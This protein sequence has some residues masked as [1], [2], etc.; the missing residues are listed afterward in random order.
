MKKFIVFIFIFILAWCTSDDEKSQTQS[1]TWENSWLIQ[2]GSQLPKEPQKEMIWEK[3][4]IDVE[5][6]KWK[7][8]F[9]V[10]DA[11]VYLNDQNITW[12]D[13]KTFEVL[14][15]DEA[16]NDCYSKDASKVFLSEGWITRE[17]VWALSGSFEKFKKSF[18]YT[19]DKSNIYF[20]G[21][22]IPVD[23]KSFEV[24]SQFVAKDKNTV[25]V[26]WV[27]MKEFDAQTFRQ[28]EDDIFQDKNFTY[29]ISQWNIQIINE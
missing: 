24:F 2:S 11:G 12:A 18:Y 5:K 3:K 25:Y 20:R 15:C 7:N 23:Y 29:N 21:N 28:K 1:G 27:A 8:T 14:F 6:V 17:V 22:S 19:K 26:G 4:V 13:V 16:G 10:N 9:A